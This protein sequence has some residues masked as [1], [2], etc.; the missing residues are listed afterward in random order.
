MRT[1]EINVDELKRLLTR[2]V[3][4]TKHC[5]V[6]TLVE[7]YIQLNKCVVRHSKLWTR[8][9]LPQVRLYRTKQHIECYSM[10][11]IYICFQ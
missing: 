11:V 9:S 1:V 6:E 8:M 2:A 4:I 7:L 5:Q 3:E 10:H